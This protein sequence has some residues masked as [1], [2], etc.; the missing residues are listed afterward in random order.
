MLC[1]MTA[2]LIAGMGSA[3]RLAAP[4]EKLQ[5]HPVIWLARQ[6]LFWATIAV[7]L[8]PYLFLRGFQ[9]LARKRL[10]MNTPRSTI[11]AAALG[12]VEVGGKAA[13][14][15]MLVSPLANAD[16]YFYRVLLRVLR[17]GERNGRL[18]VEQMCAPLFVD[19]GTGQMLL[20]PQGA[21]LLLPGPEVDGIGSS[22]LTHVLARH[23]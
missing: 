14:P 19:D 1:P 15:Y 20:D 10:I 4:L 6:P 17:P 7:V 5:H 2:P 11:R 13:G 21:D 23:G 3:A 12:P 18:L 22:Y 9:L 8:G 16:C